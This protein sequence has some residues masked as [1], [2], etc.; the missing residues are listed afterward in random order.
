MRYPT[1]TVMD[2]PKTS[3][4]KLKNL[5]SRFKVWDKLTVEQRI[6]L[7]LLVV[8][9]FILPIALVLVV[10]PKILL[11]SRVGFLTTP[12]N[13]SPHIRTKSLPKGTLGV[14]YSAIVGGYDDDVYDRLGM[15]ISNLP[16]GLAQDDCTTDSSKSRAFIVCRVKGVPQAAG[17]FKIDV[18]LTDSKGGRGVETVKLIVS[19]DETST[20][21]SDRTLLPSM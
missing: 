17:S 2:L 13:T 4:P 19:K 7:I 9:L 12:A 10:S 3:L 16:A 21:T 1:L 20:P 14:R 15:R 8:L 5:K 11:F 18:L 6:T